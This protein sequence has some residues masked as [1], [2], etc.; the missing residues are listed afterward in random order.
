[1]KQCCD[2][3]PVRQAIEMRHLVFIFVDHFEPRTRE[4][5]EA[6]GRGYPELARK[7]RDADGR[8]PRHTWFYDGTD[9][10]VL[11]ALRQILIAIL[12]AVLSI[13]G[14]DKRVAEPLRRRLRKVERTYHRSPD[15]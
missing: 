9:P 5:V 13:L 3:Q 14:Y 8:S 12:V 15:E 2:V 7:F 4:E 10:A 1:M 6:W 11:D